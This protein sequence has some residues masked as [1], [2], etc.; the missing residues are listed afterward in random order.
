MKRVMTSSSSVIPAIATLE[1]AATGPATGTAT[2][3][4]T[5]P[6]DSIDEA[7]ADH[8]EVALQAGGEPGG[9]GP[10]GAARPLSINPTLII[11]LAAVY[12]IWSSTYLAI[13]FAIAELPPL[14]MAGG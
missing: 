2:A 10:R 4:A 5:D 13:R 7:A 12:V 3:A 1:P 8:R 6:R 9:P 14:L 11:S